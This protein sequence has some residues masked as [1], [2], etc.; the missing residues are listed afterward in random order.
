MAENLSRDRLERRV[1]FAM[2]FRD[3]VT[4]LP[5]TRD[6]RVAAEGLGAPVRAPSGLFV[7]FDMDP[8]A[9]RDIKVTAVCPSGRFADFEEVITAP[10]HVPDIPPSSLCMPRALR[11]TG[12]YEP[13]EGLTGVAGWLVEDD[14]MA[15]VA[16]A[17]ISIA[18]RHAGN[19]DFVSGYK[20]V[21]DAGGGFVAVANDLGDVRPDPAPPR[22]DFEILGWL[23]VTRSAPPSRFTEFLPLRS[24]RLAR[25]AAPFRWKDLQTM[26]PP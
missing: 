19:Q 13:P 3:P 6:L 5:V 26:S 2:D 1:M 25:I 20:A 10:E 4:R 8:P 24:G 17:E 14:G 23:V 7:W 18:F 22:S 11:P 12:L 16:G 9:K 21:T 15:P